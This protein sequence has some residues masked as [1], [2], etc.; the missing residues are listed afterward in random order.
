MNSREVTCKG[1]SVG[2]ANKHKTTKVACAHRLQR[3]SDQV[4]DFLGDFGREIGKLGA[5]IASF[6]PFWIGF[7]AYVAHRFASYLSSG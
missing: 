1:S 4:C 3:E 7:S 6:G 5:M 2:R